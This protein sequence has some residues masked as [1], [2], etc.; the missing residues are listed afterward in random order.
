[1]NTATFIPR[2]AQTRGEILSE[3]SSSLTYWEPQSW[4]AFFLRQDSLLLLFNS[5]SICWEPYIM[6]WD[7]N[8]RSKLTWQKSYLML[9]LGFYISLSFVASKGFR[10]LA[11]IKQQFYY[12]QSKPA[13]KNLTDSK[14]RLQ[15][16]INSFTFL[17]LLIEVFL[18]FII[19]HEKEKTLRER[20]LQT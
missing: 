11:L 1:M 18:I 12:T 20:R 6:K 10:T 3:N 19:S 8:D 16:S 2:A 13:K 5:P 7:K 17:W 15:G 4:L 9:P 14:R